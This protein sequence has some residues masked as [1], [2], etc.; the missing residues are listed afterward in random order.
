[1]REI[2]AHNQVLIRDML[3]DGLLMSHGLLDAAAI[4]QALL[5]DP[6]GQDPIIYRVLDLVEAEAWARAWR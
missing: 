6:H 1:M 4:G 2:F 5:T 3:L